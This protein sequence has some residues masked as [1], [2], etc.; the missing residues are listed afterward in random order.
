VVDIIAARPHFSALNQG[1]SM[2][3]GPVSEQ[4]ARGDEARSRRGG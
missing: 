1:F 4:L 3:A 2:F